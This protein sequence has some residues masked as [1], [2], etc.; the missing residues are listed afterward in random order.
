MEKVFHDTAKWKA[1]VGLAFG[2]FLI[3]LVLC[4]LLMNSSASYVRD[5]FEYDLRDLSTDKEM[6][7]IEKTV[8]I[9]IRC[10][11]LGLA[12]MTIFTVRNLFW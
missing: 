3:S 10:F 5:I 7:V 11:I 4:F 1:F 6:L 9:C 2:S 8:K 12:F